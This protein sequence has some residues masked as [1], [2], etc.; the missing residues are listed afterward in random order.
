LQIPAKSSDYHDWIDTDPRDFNASLSSANQT[1]NN[2]IKPLVRV[3][4]Y[5]NAKASYPFESYALE[6][7]I[8]GNGFIAQRL[9][10]GQLKD[11]FY[12]FVN[13]VSAGF[14]APQWKT[15]AVA[16]LKKVAEETQ[17]LES[18]GYCALAESEIK[19]ILPSLG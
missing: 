8:V 6:Q 11:Y 2:L 4:K 1:H 13:E 9:L 5:W 18:Q 10:G 12:S 15:N 17:Q 14:F 3:L 7:K 19:K 16:R